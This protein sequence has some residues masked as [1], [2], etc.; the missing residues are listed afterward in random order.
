MR[1]KTLGIFGPTDPQVA[2]AFPPNAPT[3]FFMQAPVGDLRLLSARE[4]YARFKRVLEAAPARA[5]AALA[6][7][8]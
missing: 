6:R 1:A 4:V 3:N 8:A 5:S 2:G 7:P